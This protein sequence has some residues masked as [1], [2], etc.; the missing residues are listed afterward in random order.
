MPNLSALL[1]NKS[2]PLDISEIK[3]DLKFHAINDVNNNYAII[4]KE[5]EVEP[6][7]TTLDEIKNA[8][9]NDVIITT[10]YSKTHPKEGVMVYK[11]SY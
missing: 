3:C 2:F 11:I 8:Q 1:F 4:L 10:M 6:I 5:N 9:E 7:I